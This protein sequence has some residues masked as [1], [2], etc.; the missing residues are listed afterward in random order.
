M[1]STIRY[2]GK[3]S[4]YI[5]GKCA[6]NKEPNVS[7]FLV[8][9]LYRY[10]R[11]RI[12]KIETVVDDQL[13]IPVHIR[14]SGYK[15]LTQRRHAHNIA[16][17]NEQFYQRLL[18]AEKKVSSITEDNIKHVKLVNNIKSHFTKLNDT[19]RV[20]KLTQIQKENEY[21]LHRLQKARPELSVT[22]VQAWYQGHVKFREGR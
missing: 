18:K 21:F 9:K 22:E 19:V 10:H 12:L 17:E 2:D 20:R 7:K 13:V 4:D 8:E 14:K 15:A 11:E 3:P 6:T 16:I 5:A 1:S